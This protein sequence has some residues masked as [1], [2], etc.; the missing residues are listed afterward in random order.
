MKGVNRL[1]L[2]L[3]L[4]LLGAI[5]DG[6]AQDDPARIGFLSLLP[7]SGPHQQGFRQGLQD[8]GYTEGKTI[9]IEARRGESID[10]LRTL[11]GVLVNSKVNVL[12][13]AGAPATRAAMQRSATIPVV[14]IAVG[15]PVAGGFAASLARP[16]RNATGVSVVATELYPKRL[17]LL[18]Q[19]APNARHIAVL[20]NPSHP[21]IQRYLAEMRVA[22]R[23]LGVRLQTLGAR[24]SPE[25]GAVLQSIRKYPPQAILVGGDLLYL[26]HKEEVATALRM[27]RV[28]AIFASEDF[29]E[30][31]ALMSYGPDLRETGRLATFYVDKILKG[32][33]PSELSIQEIST[34]Q[35]VIDL[36][37][38]REWRMDVP[39][40]L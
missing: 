23:A 8:L 13:T 31:G 17:E 2:S 40:E 28:P 3:G 5:S 6:T 16:G 18:N 38:A 4:V 37:L 30:H 7:Q 32:A 36:R 25:L 21:L 9:V 27:A 35:L 1:F 10:E 26:V 11:A 33:S 19:L 12:V 34:F 24:S 15:D 14:F 22:A 39:R 29:H 20:L